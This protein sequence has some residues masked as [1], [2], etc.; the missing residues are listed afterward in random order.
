MIKIH[1]IRDKSGFIWQFEVKGHAG[2]S[3]PGT[4]DIVCAAVSVTAYTAVGSL[5][6]L[7]GIKGCF[8]EKDGYMLCSIPS[9]I[10][11]D[12]KQTVGIILETTLVGFKQ[13]EMEYRRYVTVL[14]EEV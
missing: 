3:K 12:K 10:P 4:V 9:D 5:D 8:K 6:E 7:A 2:Y 1:I 13:I 14:E 11:S